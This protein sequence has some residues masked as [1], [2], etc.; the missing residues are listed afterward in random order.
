MNNFKV[1]KIRDV[2]TPNRAHSNDAGI[3]FFMPK[4]TE[5]F[6]SDLFGKNGPGKYTFSSDGE[7]LYIGAHSSIL[8]PAGIKTEIP[9]GYA[10]VFFNK[11]SVAS[12]LEVLVGAQVVDHLYDGEVHIDLHNVSN[13]EVQLNESHKLVQMLIIPLIFPQ[14]KEVDRFNELY[15]SAEKNEDFRGS[16]GFGSTDGR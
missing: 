9:K 14:V 7:S 6:K 11:S 12:Q 5:Q 1:F 15:D 3:D 10:G 4:F 16:N 13:T 2:E 8:I